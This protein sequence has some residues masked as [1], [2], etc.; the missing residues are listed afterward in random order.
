MLLRIRL[1]AD[2]AGISSVAHFG[3]MRFDAVVQRDEDASDMADKLDL[4]DGRQFVLPDAPDAL[5]VVIAVLVELL[6]VVI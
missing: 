2:D 3:R 5:H 4:D 6:R 1:M